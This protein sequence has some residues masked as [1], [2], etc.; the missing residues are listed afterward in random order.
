MARRK[1]IPVNL[2]PGT[3]DEFSDTD[4]EAILIGA[5]D[6][7]FAGGRTLLTKLLKG[8]KDK[9]ILDRALDDSSA[10]GYFSEHTLKDIQG[11]VDWVMSKG[12]LS[13]EYYGTLPLLVHTS[14]GWAIVKRIRIDELLSQFDIQLMTEE[15]PYD[16]T[17]L[18]KRNRE[19]ISEFLKAIGQTKDVKYIPL[20][21]AWKA[22]DFKKIKVEIQKAIET[23]EA[24]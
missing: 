14:S 16:M 6:M 23:L 10:Y 18:R 7:I 11:R 9:V 2:N 17:Y 12:Y 13:Y 19:L 3:Y 8:S 4:L 22:I 15:E 5:D 20:L 24:E 1:K 21:K